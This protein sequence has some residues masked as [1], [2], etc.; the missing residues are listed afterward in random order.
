M[1]TKIK[2]DLLDNPT[3]KAFIDGFPDKQFVT[4]LVEFIDNYHVIGPGVAGVHVVEG[5][6]GVA[7]MLR[8]LGWGGD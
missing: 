6:E 5:L 1:A 8:G 7:G 3:M 2:T 4:E